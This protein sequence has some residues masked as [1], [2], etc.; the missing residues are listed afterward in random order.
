M[1][2]T[3]PLIIGIGN[4]LRGDDG[5]GPDVAEKLRAAGIPTMTFDGD[6]AELMELWVGHERVIIV[7]ATQSQA[8]VGTVQRFDANAEAL[9][10]HL[11]R[12]STHQFGVGEAVEMARALNRLPSRLTIYGIEGGD[13]SLGA[14][15]STDVERAVPTV[16][17]RIKAELSS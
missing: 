2:E 3:F 10:A 15:L 4:P 1:T 7:D 11:F 9:P 16:V 6:G 12:H 17:Q 13:F 8:T 5:V 14:G